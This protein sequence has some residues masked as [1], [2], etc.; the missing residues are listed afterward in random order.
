MAVRMTLLKQ[1]SLNKAE[2]SSK[3]GHLESRGNGSNSE[4]EGEV[5]INDSDSN[6]S[7]ES[8]RS[9]MDAGDQEEMKFTDVSMDNTEKK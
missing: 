6:Q 1:A 5:D 2:S 3:V 8:L 9:N 7:K 4:L